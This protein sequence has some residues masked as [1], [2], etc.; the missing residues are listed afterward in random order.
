[1]HFCYYNEKK[2]VLDVCLVY[3]KLAEIEQRK[4]TRKD[5]E[6]KRKDMQQNSDI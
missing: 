4:A 1:M 6:N 3:I 2:E 5:A